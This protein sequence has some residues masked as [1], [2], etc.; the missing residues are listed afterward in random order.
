NIMNTYP[1]DDNSAIGILRTIAAGPLKATTTRPTPG[2]QQTLETLNVAFGPPLSATVATEGDL[3][4]AALAVLSEDPQYAE[5]IQI[6]SGANA[7]SD[8]KHFAIDPASIAVTA[9]A[10]LALQTRIKWKRDAEGK[11][12]FEIEKKASGDGTVKLLVERLLAY[13]PH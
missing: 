2:P 10:L 3:A 12:T 1:L 7:L 11:W 4:R 13:H 6:M 9:A 5:P 8:P